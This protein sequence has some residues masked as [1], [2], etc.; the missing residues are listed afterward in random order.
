AL[1]DDRCRSEEPA[2]TVVAPGHLAR[3]FHHDRAR[4]L[5]REAAADI[6]LPPVDRAG[7]P[8]VR[9]DDLG[10]VFRQRGQEVHALQAVT[11]A[12]WPGETLGLV[13]ESGSGKTT[14]ARTLLGIVGP[15]AG[16][17]EFDGRSLAGTLSKRT[18]DDVRS[19]QIVFQNPDSALNRRHTVRRML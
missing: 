14:L 11:A 2:I 8:L 6:S 17:V 16:S 19:L 5:P 18:A 9:F 3:C 12:I 15:T 4:T 1:A 13:G 7:E 10:K